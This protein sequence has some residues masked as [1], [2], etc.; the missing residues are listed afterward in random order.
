MLWACFVARGG[1]YSALLPLWEGYDEYS[2]FAYVQH[3]IA[4]WT[5]PI[6]NVTRLSQEVAASL[7]AAPL[8]WMLRGRSPRG[9]PHDAFWKLPPQEREAR[10]ATLQRA[11]GDSARQEDPTA[12]GIYE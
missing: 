12:E 9:I 2:H 5:L 11:G 8:T 7:D 4:H 6:P 3:L 1:F 10:I